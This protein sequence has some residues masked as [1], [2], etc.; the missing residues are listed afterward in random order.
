MSTS[1]IS[2]SINKASGSHPFTPSEEAAALTDFHPGASAA[3]RR[4]L[5][6]CSLAHIH[7]RV[8]LGYFGEVLEPENSFFYS[9]LEGR[10]ALKQLCGFYKEQSGNIV[11]CGLVIIP[12]YYS[13]YY[14][15]T[16]F[17]AGLLCWHSAP[18]VHHLHL[19]S[20][21]PPSCRGASPKIL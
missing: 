5:T 19:F 2:L 10:V 3:L 16:R 8:R 7:T 1:T 14:F 6:V 20:L 13:Y 17:S 12:L 9:P 18:R 21:R 4:T 15:A 11:M